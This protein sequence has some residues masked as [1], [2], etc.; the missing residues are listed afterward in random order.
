MIGAAFR[1][2]RRR[3]ARAAAAARSAAATAVSAKIPAGSAVRGVWRV[4]AAAAR[5][6]AAVG[7]AIDRTLPTAPPAAAATPSRDT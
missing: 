1:R 4:A 7:P 2:L 3:T 6:E 5:G